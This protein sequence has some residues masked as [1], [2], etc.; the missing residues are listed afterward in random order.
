MIHFL[1]LGPLFLENESS[2][3]ENSD[4]ELTAFEVF[5]NSEPVKKIY[6]DYERDK[7]Y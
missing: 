6:D 4:R 7:F 1:R 5:M 2:D 3:E